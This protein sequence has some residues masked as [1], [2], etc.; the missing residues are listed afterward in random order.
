MSRTLTWEHI[1]PKHQEREEDLDSI[2]DGN[3]WES[4][5]ARKVE[6]PHFLVQ[7]LFGRKSWGAAPVKN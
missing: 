5:D 2:S 6:S 3:R 7:T 4:V 1:L